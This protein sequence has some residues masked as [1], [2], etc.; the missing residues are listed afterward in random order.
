[1]TKKPTELKPG[2]VPQK[3]GHFIQGRHKPAATNEQKKPVKPKSKL[4][5]G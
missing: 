5:E 3:G 2:D 1:M 4:A